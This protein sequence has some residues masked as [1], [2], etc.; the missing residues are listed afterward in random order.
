MN[1]LCAKKGIK[2]LFSVARTLKQNGVAERKNRTLIE[3]ARTMLAD[4]LLPIPFWAEAVNTACYLLN[5][6]FDLDFLTNSMNYY[7]CLMT[8]D[9]Q[10]LHDELKKMIAQEVVSKAMDDAIRQAFE[11]EKRNIASQKRA[12]SQL[13]LQCKCWCFIIVYLGGKI[14]IDASTLPNADLPIDLTKPD[15]KDD[16]NAFLSDGIFNGAYDDEN[17]IL[18]QQF[19]QEERFKRLLQ[20]NKHC[21]KLQ[22]VGLLVVF[23]IWEKGQLAQ[24]GSLRIKGMREDRETA[25]TP[26]VSLYRH[27]VKDEDVDVHVYRSMIGSLMYLT[28][29]RSDIMLAVYAW[30]DSPFELEAFS[31]SDYGGASLDRKSTTCGCQFLGR[32]LIS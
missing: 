20:H 18:S 5:W 2:R 12:A 23:A 32:R 10:V 21:I 27:L 29:S 31:D 28:T 1:E 30:L 24:S 4:S 22:K 11:E 19:K 3:A 13:K 7:S 6:M 14:S 9:E 25:T 26:I 15:L 16:S 17:D 8:E